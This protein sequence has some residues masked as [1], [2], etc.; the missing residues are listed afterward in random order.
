MFYFL[1][2]CYFSPGS[3]LL[4]ALGKKMFFYTNFTVSLPLHKYLNQST[5]RQT[6]NVYEHIYKQSFLGAINFNSP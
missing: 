3:R 2:S 4:K 5:L 1:S 6:L